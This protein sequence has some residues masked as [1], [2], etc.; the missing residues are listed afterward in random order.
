[1]KDD[2]KMKYEKVRK[3]IAEHMRERHYRVLPLDEM[4]SDRWK[5]CELLGFVEGIIVYENVYI[6]SE[7]KVSEN[8]W[9]GPLV[10]L[11]AT[12]GLEIGDGCDISC[13][14]MIFT[15]STHLRCISKGN[16]KISQ[17]IWQLQRKPIETVW[18][19]PF[20]MT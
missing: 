16:I 13:D 20:T 2:M 19:S 5:K 15:Y 3:E 10:V 18:L 14:A 1:M 12:G 8:V 7:P 6:Y 9:I 11:D 4:L 17:R